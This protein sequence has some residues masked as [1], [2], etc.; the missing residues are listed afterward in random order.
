MRYLS[1]ERMLG[2]VTYILVEMER[3]VCHISLNALTVSR[4][5]A[6]AVVVRGCF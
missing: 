4:F 6:H 1:R 2:V 5:R 3:I